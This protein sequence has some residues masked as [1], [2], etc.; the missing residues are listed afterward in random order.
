MSS[1]NKNPQIETEGLIDSFI[2]DDTQKIDVK[3][4]KFEFIN[5]AIRGLITPANCLLIL[6]RT[7]L[8]RE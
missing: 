6:R 3:S 5:L 1:K 7:G 4:I 2:N 8:W